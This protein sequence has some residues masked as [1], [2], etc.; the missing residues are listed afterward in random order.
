MITNYIKDKKPENNSRVFCKSVHGVWYAAIFAN[1][2][3][4][5]YAHTCYDVPIGEVEEWAYQD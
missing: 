3:F 5:P 2:E 4:Y 1:D